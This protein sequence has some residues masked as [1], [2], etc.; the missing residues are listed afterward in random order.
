MTHR[1]QISV[2]TVQERPSKTNT[3]SSN[4][5]DAISLQNS[6]L[7]ISSGLRI[8]GRSVSLRLL[9]IYT[10]LVSNSRHSLGKWIDDQLFGRCTI[11]TDQLTTPADYARSDVPNNWKT[12]MAQTWEEPVCT[13]LFWVLKHVLPRENAS[14]HYWETTF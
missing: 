5:D 1:F 9:M 14:T 11:I 8:Y 13:G 7:I 12:T 3:N 4:L 2:L 6:N 10:S